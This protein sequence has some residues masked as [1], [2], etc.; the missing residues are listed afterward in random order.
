MITT[1]GGDDT[2]LDLSVAVYQ[3][4]GLV[5]QVSFIQ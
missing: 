1:R 5:Y 2:A 4:R 3:S